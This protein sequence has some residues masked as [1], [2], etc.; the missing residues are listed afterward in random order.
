MKYLFLVLCFTLFTFCVVPKNENKEEPRPNVIFILAD[1]LGYGD[2]GC[3]NAASKIPTP[4]L[5]QLAQEGMRFTDAHTPS[6]VCSP[7]RYGFLT[8]QYS[9]RGPLKKGVLQS[10]DLPIIAD[11]LVTIAEV[12][13]QGG[14][15]TAHIGK[16]HL[17]FDWKVKEGYPTTWDINGIW[18]VDDRDERIDLSDGIQGGPLDAG[19]DYSYGFDCPN[20]PPYCFWENKK[21]IGEIPNILKPDSLYGNPGWFQK[22]WELGNVFPDLETKALAYLDEA[23]KKDRPFFLYFALTAPHVPLYPTGA[24]KGKSQAGLYGDFVVDVD[25]LVGKV[26]AKLQSLGIAENTIL[27]F[28]S[29]NGSPARVEDPIRGRNY[30]EGSG[31]IIREFGHKANGELRG[32]KGDTWEGGHRVPMIVRWPGKIKSNTE[33]NQTV[34][35]TDWA[36]FAYSL[37]G[38]EK[39]ADQSIDSYDLMSTLENPEISIR[40]HIIHHSAGGKFAIR[41]GDWKLILQKGGSGYSA[42][43]DPEGE[44]NEFEGQLYNLKDDFTEK[45]NLYGKIPQKVRDLTLLLNKIKGKNNRN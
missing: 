28:T 6:S 31:E 26:N 8:G 45:N 2:L 33:N 3:Y 5:D 36:S 43:Y 1:D 29:D 14:Y 21:I 19:F 39:P 23:G 40:K 10:Y 44:K 41:Q 12:F 22:D 25:N 30:Y 4:H 42:W 24:A 17:G 11:S 37:T 34:C 9:W 38:K 15:E 32:L 18:R 7:T 20:M 16:W 13:Q 35:L 27:I